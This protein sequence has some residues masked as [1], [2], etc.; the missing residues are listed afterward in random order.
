MNCAIAQSLEAFGDWW[1]L[2]IVREALFG[3]TRFSD[4][5]DHLG[6]ATNILSNR[7]GHLVEH[8]ILERHPVEGGRT[9]YEYRLTEKGADLGAVM[10]AMRQW[11][12]RW[13]FGE[14]REPLLLLDRRTG[15]PIPK[16]T[17]LDESGQEMDWA[18]VVARPGPG[19]RKAPP[20]PA[21]TRR[22]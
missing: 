14:G 13:V 16:M 4:F 19:A 20:K 3:T 17:L 9:R 8:G 7:L 22:S 15:K 5:A 18:N 10:I 11:A 21:R 1:S 12:N 6:I 2:L